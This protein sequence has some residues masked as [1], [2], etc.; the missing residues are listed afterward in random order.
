LIDMAAGEDVE[1]RSG[2]VVVRAPR[3][4][5]LPR[6]Y[7]RAFEIVGRDGLAHLAYGA[8]TAAY[9]FHGR[10]EAEDVVRRLRRRAVIGAYDYLVEESVGQASAYPG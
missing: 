6:D 5:D 10:R 9:V 2:F 1:A 7:L 3:N 8:R 4:G